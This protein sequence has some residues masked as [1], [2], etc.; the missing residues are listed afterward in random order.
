MPQT[1]RNN[2]HPA[3]NPAKS[4]GGSAK[5][6]RAA[7]PYSSGITGCGFML[8]EMTSLIPLLSSPD[9]D[10]LLRKEIEDNAVLSLGKAKTRSRMIT[11]FRRRYAA[12]PPSFWR[13]FLKLDRPGRIIALYYALLRTYLV[14]KEV[15]LDVVLP[16]LR[17]ANPV[18]TRADAER[19]IARIGE[20]DSFVAS[21]SEA[22]RERVASSCVSML[23]EVGMLGVSGRLAA[24]PIP[25]SVA[26]HF[27]TRGESWYLEALGMPLYEIRRI[28]EEGGASR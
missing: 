26:Q 17:S 14:L 7:S 28:A 2:P 21:W 19:L 1:N 15:H 11:E 10:A 24:V 4:A 16:R 12:L 22:T 3:A 5:D 27:V 18:V 9:A 6:L 23:R 13:W 20:T 8:D 25:V